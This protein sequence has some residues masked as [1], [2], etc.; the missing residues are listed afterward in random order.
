MIYGYLSIGSLENY[1]SYYEEFAELALKSYENWPDEYWIDV[2]SERWQSYV[3]DSLVPELKEKGFDG[4]FV[5]NCDVYYQYPTDEIYEGL[6]TIID[7]IRQADLAVMINGGDLFVTRMIEEGHADLISAISQE[8]VFSCIRDYKTDE[9]ARQEAEE[10]DYFKEY[11]ERA[12]DAGIEVYL[13]EYTT[14]EALIAEID[15]YCASHGFHYY[16]SEHVELD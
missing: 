11:V 5:D 14:D 9:F 15:Q 8:S 1:R 3:V 6:K 7:G 12:G 2:S 10:T 13:I 4:V 16:I